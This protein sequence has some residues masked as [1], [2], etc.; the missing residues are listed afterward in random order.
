M[1]MWAMLSVVP[2][3]YK[4]VK[5]KERLTEMTHSVSMNIPKTQVVHTDVE[6]VIKK[7]SVLLGKLRI[8]KG[9][10]QWWPSGASKNGYRLSWSALAD[11]F[12]QHGTP[13]K[14]R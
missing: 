13:I 3:N 7:D 11:V 6:F 12:V 10:I 2:P 8:S 14:K 4:V 1:I 5:S 9:N